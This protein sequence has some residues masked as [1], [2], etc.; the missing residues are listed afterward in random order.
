MF[1]TPVPA[2]LT[3]GFGQVVAFN[4]GL[5]STLVWYL[6]ADGVVFSTLGLWVWVSVPNSGLK[7]FASGD[8]AGRQKFIIFSGFRSCSR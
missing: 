3:A 5:S 7:Y 2:R 4:R 8:I 1:A 6:R